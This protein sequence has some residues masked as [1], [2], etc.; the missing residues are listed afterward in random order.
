[1]P[2]MAGFTLTDRL[3]GNGRP[4]CVQLNLLGHENHWDPTSRDSQAEFRKYYHDI[5][6][7]A[8]LPH[9]NQQG[10]GYASS[11]RHYQVKAQREEAEKKAKAWLRD[12]KNQAAL[13][14][15]LER[16]DGGEEG[17]QNQ[18]EENEGEDDDT[19]D[20]KSG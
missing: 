15:L 11:F 16:D 1:M 4:K 7:D 20:D 14:T 5:P 3:T 13:K 8:E 2:P 18:E 9:F 12:P 10:A 6:E 17:E 19:E